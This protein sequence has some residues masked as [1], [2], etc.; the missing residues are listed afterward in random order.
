MDLFFLEGDKAI[1]STIVRMLEISSDVILKITD[2]QD[3][4]DF[5]K[6]KMFNYCFKAFID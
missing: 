6:T 3:M 4:Q 2:P 5:I 1:T